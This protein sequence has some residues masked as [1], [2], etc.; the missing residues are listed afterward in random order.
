MLNINVIKL[1]KVVKWWNL[2]HHLSA[3]NE[4]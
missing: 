3:K 1:A 4:T 2:S